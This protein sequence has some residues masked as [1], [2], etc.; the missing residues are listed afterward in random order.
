MPC[1]VASEQP[2]NTAV[3]VIHI[4]PNLPPPMCTK[5]VGKFSLRCLVSTS[6]VSKQF[7]SHL[8][9]EFL[10]FFYLYNTRVTDPLP[11]L[12]LHCKDR[13]FSPYFDGFPKYCTDYTFLKKRTQLLNTNHAPC[14]IKYRDLWW[15]ATI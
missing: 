3:I 7:I 14:T 5:I 13:R 10:N 8:H 6:R 12:S 9:G 2:C 11:P 1:T 4:D 15:V